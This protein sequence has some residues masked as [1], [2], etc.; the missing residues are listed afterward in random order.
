VKQKLLQVKYAG[1]NIHLST[2]KLSDLQ[3]KAH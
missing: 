1:F 3:H 2:R